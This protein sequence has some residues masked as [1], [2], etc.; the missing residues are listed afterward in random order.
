MLSS[1]LF[2]TRMYESRIYYYYVMNKYAANFYKN[3]F[4]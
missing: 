4:N 1:L 3:I 2:D